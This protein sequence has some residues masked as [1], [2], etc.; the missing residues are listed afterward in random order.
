MDDE[1]KEVL[2]GKNLDGAR[3]SLSCQPLS[4]SEP[5]TGEGKELEPYVSFR[6]RSLPKNHYSNYRHETMGEGVKSEQKTIYYSRVT[7]EMGGLDFIQEARKD[8][9]HKVA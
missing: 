6:V 1:G 3:I 2:R 9:T 7:T 4:Y 8:E 5:K